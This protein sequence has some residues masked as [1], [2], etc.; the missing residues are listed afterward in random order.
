MRLMPMIHQGRNSNWACEFSWLKPFL[1]EGD[2]VWC[3]FCARQTDSRGPQDGDPVRW[4]GE[5]FARSLFSLRAVASGEEDFHEDRAREGGGTS[6]GTQDKVKSLEAALSALG[7]EENAAK[8]QIQEAVRRA[9]E[10]TWP[11]RPNPDTIQAEAWLFHVPLTAQGVVALS[12]GPEQS[13]TIFSN[14]SDM[15]SAVPS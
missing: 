6:Q 12:A 10:V 1:F 15:W 5:S 4:T 3:L 2:F 11:V 8:V 14:T 9:K 7:P 13:S